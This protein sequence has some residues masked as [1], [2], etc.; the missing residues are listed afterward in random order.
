MMLGAPK[1]NRRFKRLL[2]LITRRYKSFKSEVAKRPPSNCTIGRSSG[3]ITGRTS[4]IIQDGSFPELRNASNTSRRLIAR[5]R[6]C[7][8]AV[9]I[10]LLRSLLLYLNRC[11]VVAFNCFCTHSSLN[12]LPYRSRYARYSFQKVI[13]SYQV[14]YLHFLLQ[15]KK[16]NKLL[17]QAREDMSKTS[18]MRLGIPLKYQI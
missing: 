1:S 18:P 16:R 4:K 12:V 14:V 10:L 17:L 6:R 9:L 5:V 15:H 7:P 13:A 3:G 11:L 2:R 8:C